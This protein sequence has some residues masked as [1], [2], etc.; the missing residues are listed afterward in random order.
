MSNEH[1]HLAL[2]R[3]YLDA[4]SSGLCSQIKEGHCKTSVS[5]A[6]AHWE[7]WGLEHLSSE[8]SMR[9]GTA[10]AWR[11]EG[12]GGTSEQPSLADGQV[13]DKVEPGFFSGKKERA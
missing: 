1:L 7:V 2:L 4:A 8:G 6:E 9:D 12:F 5:P 11:R 3:P 13:S 10:S